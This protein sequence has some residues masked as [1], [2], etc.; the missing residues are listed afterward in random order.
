[1]SKVVHK[2][3]KFGIDFLPSSPRAPHPSLWA[4]MEESCWPIRMSLFIISYHG[5]WDAYVMFDIKILTMV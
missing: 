1:M 2:E 4:R 3:I 5:F